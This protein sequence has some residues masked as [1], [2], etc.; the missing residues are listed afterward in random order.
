MIGIKGKKGDVT[1]ST[2]ILI[3]LGLAVLVM[4]IVGF[5]RGWDFFFGAFDNAPSELQT[6]AKACALYAQGS[7]TI[8]F[9]SYRLAGDELVNCLDDRITST[10]KSD[11]VRYDKINC[12]NDAQAR[13]VACENAKPDTKIGSTTCAQILGVQNSTNSSN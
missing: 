3:V 13:R 6:I 2:V 7:L 1:I 11:V 10:L 12:A 5:T 4:L 9:C 8:D